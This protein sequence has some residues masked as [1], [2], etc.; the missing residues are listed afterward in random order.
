MQHQYCSA[1]ITHFARVSYHITT[2]IPSKTSMVESFLRISAGLPGSLS[3]VDLLFCREQVSTCFC[4]KDSTRDIISGVLKTRSAEGCSL[5]GCIVTYEKGIP[6]EIISC[7]FSVSFK[8]P[9][10]N[11]VKSLFLVALKTVDCKL[12]TAVKRGLSRKIS[13]EIF[14]KATFQNMPIHVLEISAKLQNAE[15][16]TATLLK[17]VS[18]IDAHPTISKILGTLRENFSSGVSFRTIIGG[19]IG[20]VDLLKRNAT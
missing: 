14:R 4:R 17:S 2:E 5:Q 20:Q 19:W 18:I 7:K 11:F 16:Y 13:R 15:I 9:L 1:T 6:L 8:A 3:Y 10:T 12:A